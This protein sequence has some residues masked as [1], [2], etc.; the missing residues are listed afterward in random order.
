LYLRYLDGRGFRV[1]LQRE[2]NIASDNPSDLARSPRI[3]GTSSAQMSQNVNAWPL[4][5]PSP[6]FPA[7]GLWG[8]AR[9]CFPRSPP[10]TTR[11]FARLFRRSVHFR[12]V[13]RIA[14]A[15]ARAGSSNARDDSATTFSILITDRARGRASRRPSGAICNYVRTS[16]RLQIAAGASAARI[17]VYIS[18]FPFALRLRG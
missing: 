6:R 18:L 2:L 3:P 4:R 13:G 7:L 17:D 11:R 10:P 16:A 1:S 8:G 14:R 9:L 15:N 5:P 12:C